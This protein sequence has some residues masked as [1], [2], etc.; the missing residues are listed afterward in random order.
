MLKKPDSWEAVSKR[1]GRRTRG[2]EKLAKSRIERLFSLAESSQEQ[3]LSSESRRFIKLARLIGKR[4][5]QR[6][7]KDQRMQF[8]KSCNSLL[9][10][11]NSRNRISPKG[12]KTITCLSCGSISRYGIPRSE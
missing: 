8:C 2:Q 12:W 6:L 11:S 9:L 1:R 7:T 4:Y 10:A 3:G 5:N